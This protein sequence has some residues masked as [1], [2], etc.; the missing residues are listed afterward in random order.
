MS[1]STNDVKHTPMYSLNSIHVRILL[2]AYGPQTMAHRPWPDVDGVNPQGWLN[3]PGIMNCQNCPMAIREHGGTFACVCSLSGRGTPPGAPCA[4]G[5]R[6]DGHGLTQADYER[7]DASLA[8]RP[9]YRRKPQFGSP[10][11]EV[12][13]TT[14]QDPHAKALE[15]TREYLPKLDPYSLPDTDQVAKAIGADPAEVLAEAKTLFGK[16][17]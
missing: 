14:N 2:G 12:V 9:R 3:Y 7:R 16:E 11:N 5:I 6:D 4:Y 17:R 15:R 8:A 10:A 13:R 1:A